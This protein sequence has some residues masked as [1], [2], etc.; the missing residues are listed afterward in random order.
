M[1]GSTS[2][3][4]LN[5]CGLLTTLF[6]VLLYS[7]LLPKM[8]NGTNPVI[9]L[10]FGNEDW[11][12]DYPN[13]LVTF[14]GDVVIN[15]ST[16]AHPDYVLHTYYRTMTIIFDLPLDEMW[17]AAMLAPASAASKPLPASVSIRRSYQ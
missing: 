17:V 7:N 10:E 6:V 2:S 5:C 3:C 13:H 12:T 15:I 11:R 8:E 1:C 4:S 9:C 14:E 16:S